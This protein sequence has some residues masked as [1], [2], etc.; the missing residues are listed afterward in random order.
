MK[1]KI[2]TT[3]IM[4]TSFFATSSE[5]GVTATMDAKINCCASSDV[6]M[7]ECL[8]NAF[9]VELQPGKY[10]FSPKSGAISKHKSNWEA[11]KN[12]KEP[13]LWVVIIGAE[14]ERYLLGTEE[15]YKTEDA[16]LQANQGDVVNVEIR[17]KSKVYFWVEDMWKKRNTCDDN[18][19]SLQVEIKKIQ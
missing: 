12:K 11:R 3:F 19:G 5:A 14:N 1:I 13:W 7:N 8:T 9:F 15:Y 16:A 2:I 17:K 4:I 18:R 10:S 6:N